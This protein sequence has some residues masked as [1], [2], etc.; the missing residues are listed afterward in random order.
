VPVNRAV[1]EIARRVESTQLTPSL[2]NLEQFL[3]AL[4][5]SAPT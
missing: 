5:A 2:D 3:L 1:V 4:P